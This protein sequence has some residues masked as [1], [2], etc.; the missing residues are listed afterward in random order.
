MGDIVNLR[1]ARKIKA[2]DRTEKNAAANRMKH[3]TP[4][5]LR[6]AS[7]AAKARA[8]RAVDSHKIENE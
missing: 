6:V 3:G 7:A 5:A 1:R 4:K 8:N 2:R